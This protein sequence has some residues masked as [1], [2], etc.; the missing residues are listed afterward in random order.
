MELRRVDPRTLKKNPGNP[1]KIQPG[2]MSDA[3]LAANVNV[4]GILQPRPSRRRTARSRSSTAPGGSASPYRSAS[5][6]STSW[7]KTPTTTTR[8]GR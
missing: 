3:A 5:P 4:V 7:S 8:C 6:R 2:E 1:R